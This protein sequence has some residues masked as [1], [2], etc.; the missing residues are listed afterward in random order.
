MSGPAPVRTV[1][2]VMGT[3]ASI[4]VPG[5]EVARVGRGEVDAALASARVVLERLDTRFSHYTLDSDISQWL[6]GR[7]ASPEA[8]ADFSYVLRQCGRLREESDGVFT[9]RNPRTGTVDT[10]GYVKGFAIRRAAEGLSR[11]GIAHAMVGVGGDTFCLGRAALDRPWRVAIADPTRPRAVAAIVEANDLAVA[12]SGSVERG[13]HIWRGTAEEAPAHWRSF[14]VVG[15][16]I[17]EADA[18]ATIGY[19]MGEAGMA[20]VAARPGYRSVGVRPDGSVLAD[21]ALVSA[22]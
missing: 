10:A 9:V 12:T 13:A 3:V 19:A 16:D 5:F 17:A 22:A 15:P 18:Y 21:A 4:L 6:S 8:V 1:F 11:D 20:W 2:P 14:S 7:A